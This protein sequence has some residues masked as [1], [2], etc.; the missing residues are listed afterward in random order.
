MARVT[1]SERRIANVM[2][3]DVG[4]S[5]ATALI[6]A[7]RL[8][9]RYQRRVLREYRRHRNPNLELDIDRMVE[10]LRAA[11]V[12]AYLRAKLRVGDLLPVVLELA[13]P[14]R[15]STDFMRRRLQMSVSDVDR[16]NQSYSTDALRVMKSAS[17]KTEKALQKTLLR[18]QLAGEHV[19]EGVK[20][21]RR[22]LEAQGITDTKNYQLEAI[23]RTQTQ[24]AYAAGQ[25]AALADPT[26]S[27]YLWGFKYVTVGDA[28][29]RPEHRAL[30][31]VTLP[32][33]DIFWEKH[34]PPN[35]W[36][37][38]C[39]AIPLFREQNVVSPPESYTDPLTGR[40]VVPGADKGFAF[41]PGKIL[42]PLSTKRSVPFVPVPEGTKIPA[43]PKKTEIDQ[44]VQKKLKPRPKPEPGP[45]PTSEKK[46][47]KRKV[48]EKTGQ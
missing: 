32:K 20:S 36:N 17:V 6:V 10:L 8:G 34:K 24:L 26:V 31:G 12:F 21:L 40:G 47:T 7:E 23:F 5:V 41:D 30:E 2:D 25:H 46:A 22:T 15:G 11:M 42:D 44:K 9:M 13:T 18:T 43:V 28:R 39:T 29:V 48:A 14:F 16:L 1:R 19:R 38:R 35:G 3:G 27:K 45:K 33:E 4:L 37:C